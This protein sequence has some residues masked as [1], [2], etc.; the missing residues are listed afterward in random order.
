MTFFRGRGGVQGSG[1]RHARGGAREE[2]Q[3]L[4]LLRR[5][6]DAQVLETRLTT[7]VDVV[8]VHQNSRATLIPLIRGDSDRKAVFVRLE[9]LAA[10][11]VRHLRQLKRPLAFARLGRSER[12]RILTQPLHR[13]QQVLRAAQNRL[14]RRVIL[15]PVRIQ[16]HR[17]RRSNVFVRRAADGA[18][19]QPSARLRARRQHIAL[20]RAQKVIHRENGRVDV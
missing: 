17:P 3:R 5:D 4:A 6:F 2:D 15:Q 13:G 1:V 9:I 8:Q 20:V 11:V 7:L 16:R 14:L 10:R 18:H 12:I 19:L